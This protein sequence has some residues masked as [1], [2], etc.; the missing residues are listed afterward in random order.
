[1][2]VIARVA[3]AVMAVLAGAT[4]VFTSTRVFLV[5]C[6]SILIP[7]PIVARALKR[8][9]DLFE[10]IVLVSLGFAILFLAR[11]LAHMASGDMGYRGRS[12]DAGFNSALAIALVGVIGV[13]L[14]Y[15]ARVGQVVATR[16]RPLPREW[17]VATLTAYAAFLSLL[18]LMLFA[19]FAWQIGGLETIKGILR[20][21]SSSDSALYNSSSA[22]F[23]YGPFLCIPATLLLLASAS[24]RNLAVFIVP[25][26]ATAGL[27]L[28]VTLNRGDRQWLMMLIIPLLILPYLRRER[29]PRL[30]AV[31]VTLVV[32]FLVGITFLR[33]RRIIGP[34]Q[35]R[36]TIGRIV[37][38]P[39]VAWHEFILGPDTEMFAVLSL[40]A[41][42]MGSRFPHDPGITLKSLATNW[43]PSDFWRTKPETADLEI[44][45]RLFPD[46][47]RI[48]KAGTAPSLFGGFY[49]DSGFVG[50][51]VGAFAF[52][53]LVRFLHGYYQRDPTNRAVQVLYAIALPLVPVLLRGNPTDTAARATFVVAPV[54][55][56]FLIAG[57][58]VRTPALAAARRS[59]ATALSEGL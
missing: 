4:I 3:V 29:R 31:A 14:G 7:A 49:Y 33:D 38:A 54:V 11:P 55:V 13:Y 50:V 37:D 32:L 52:G 6:L 40:L 22:Y 43:V 36:P 46:Q 23:F 12:I 59:R 5:V 16:V 56:G 48:T 9:F 20:G 34:G 58:R 10:P 25:T 53:I 15:V 8:R 2:G 17:A 28:L 39:A 35:E 21:R 24:R 19:L 47:Y 57:R 51:F 18:G 42:D 30:I 27:V 44:Y 1:M 45:K 41:E 26:F